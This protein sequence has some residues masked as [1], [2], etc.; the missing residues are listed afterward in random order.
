MFLPNFGQPKERNICPMTI[1]NGEPKRCIKQ[2]CM[3]WR[4]DTRLPPNSLR[5]TY[6]PQVPTKGYC[7]LAGIPDSQY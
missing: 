7:G 3:V 1:A 5:N 4:W 2:E 6:E